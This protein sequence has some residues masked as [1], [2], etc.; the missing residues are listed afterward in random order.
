M[1]LSLAVNSSAK[2]SSG[3]YVAAANV[4]GRLAIPIH[5]NEPSCQAISIHVSII[6]VNEG[7]TPPAAFG[8][9]AG[10][11]PQSHIASTIPGDSVRKRSDSP[12]SARTN[13]RIPRARSTTDTSATGAAPLG[14]LSFIIGDDNRLASPIVFR[15]YR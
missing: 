8:L 7:S 5:P 15:P 12:A 2:P 6:S 1:R 3:R 4:D 10:I 9:N 11:S 13:S 14:L